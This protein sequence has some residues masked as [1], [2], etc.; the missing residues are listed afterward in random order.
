MRLSLV[1]VLALIFTTIPFVLS[2]PA[3]D[4]LLADEESPVVIDYENNLIYLYK[5]KVAPEDFAGF[6]LNP[7]EQIVLP[8]EEEFV[9]TGATLIF[10][11]LDEPPVNAFRSLDEETTEEETTEEETTEEE[12]TEE[13]TTEEETTEEETTEE[14]PTEETTEEPTEETTEEPTE[15]PTEETTEEETTEEETTEPET[16][17][18]TYTVIL[19]GDIDG[20]G[21]IEA[22]D[23][24]L[25]LRYVAKLDTL[26]DL[27]LLAANLN[28]D[29]KILADDAR[30]ILRIVALLDELVKPEPTTE[31][32]TE[33]P[34]EETTE[35]PTEETTEEAT[36]ETTE[37]DTTEE[38]TA[39]PV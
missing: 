28:G 25:V 27:Q 3:E 5:Q 14:E 1:L 19:M 23:A 2:A 12:T 16:N 17:E 6:F 4:L 7:A 39:L 29:T 20:D 11:P 32:P 8:G 24:R 37:E 30:L 35:E 38:E 22:E 21:K 10:F 18:I 15:E 34:T 9:G 36:E 31:E 26:D 13:E 33:E